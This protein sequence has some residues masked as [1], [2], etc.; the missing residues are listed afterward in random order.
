MKVIKF[1]YIFNLAAA[2]LL[3]QAAFAQT[4]IS[5]TVKDAGGEPVIGAVVMLQ[6]NTSVGTA[7][8]VDGKYSLLL[9]A[10]TKDPKLNL[11]CL[12]YAEQTVDVNGRATID[13]T[14]QNDD[15]MI[16]ETV[17]VGYGSVRKSDI[18]GSISTVKID[19]NEASKA[20]SIAA[21]LQGHAPGVQVTNNGGSPDGGVSI[22]VRGNSS[23]NCS[24]EPLYVVDGIILNTSSVTEKAMFTSSQAGLANYGGNDETNGL[25]GI[26]PQDIESM[27]VLK[28]ASATAIYGAQ[29]ENGVVLITT[30]KAK[31][32]RPSIRFNAGVDVTT[33]YE[34]R[35]ILSS[36]EWLSLY[37]TYNPGA[38]SYIY[39]DPLS[40]SGKFSD[41]IDWQDYMMHPA[42]SQR[43]YFNV[44]GKPSE[45]RYNFSFGYNNTNGIINN[46]GT[47]QYT[48]RLN[49]DKTVRKKLTFGTNVN[50]AYIDSDLAAHS[51]RLSER[52]SNIRSMVLSIPFE[53]DY[54]LYDHSDLE[55][56]NAA[57]LVDK[58]ND[59]NHYLN[60]RK[61][62]RVIPNLYAEYKIFPFLNFRSSVG[63]DVRVS[64]RKNFISNIINTTP[65]GNVAARLNSYYFNWNWDNTLNFNQQF[66]DHYIN[67]MLGTSTFSGFSS[68]Q[69]ITGW[70]IPTYELGMEGINSALY[71]FTSYSESLSRTFSYFARAVYSF[72]DR[73][74]LTATFRADGS[75]KFQDDNK[76]GYFPSGAFAWRLNQ[77]PWFKVDA[78]S[79][80]KIRVGW[81]R[82]GNQGLS[83][84]KTSTTYSSVELPIHYAS[85]EGVKTSS[86]IKGLKPDN[87]ANAG[88]K[89]ETTEST[90]IG[91]DLGLW[92][93]RFTFTAD[94]YNKETYGLLQVRDIPVSSGY[95]SIWINQ[96]DIRNRGLELSFEAVPIAAKDFEWS[97]HGNISFNR[98][99]L[100]SI[101]EDAA[102]DEIWVTTDRKE[103][104]VYYYGDDLE[105]SSYAKAALN[106]FMEGYPMGLF[107]GYKVKGIIQQGQVGTPLGEGN[108]PRGE[109]YLDY[110]D[111]NGNGYIDPEDRTIIGDPNPDFTYGF[112]TS[113]TW[114]GF[115]LNVMFNGV[116]GN[117]IYNAELCMDAQAGMT[118]LNT[119]RFV[120]DDAWSPSNPNAKW[121]AL[122]HWTTSMDN[123]KITSQYV[124]DG[125]YL[126]L[127]NVALSYDIKIKDKKS[128]VKGIGLTAS[129][130]NL[131]IWTNYHGWD[132]DVS[133]FGGDTTKMGVDMGSYPHARTFSFDVN[134]R[135]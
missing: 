41:G 119:R 47:K 82:V 81:G 43:Y 83:P 108:A 58:Y 10:G 19:E 33:C 112:G 90:N 8:D 14:M 126:R 15:M 75:S 121:P 50:L 70:N 20:T 100:V 42:L 53:V 132:P 62:F 91:L 48:M 63:A 133:S 55:E 28:D 130:S 127:S 56:D 95:S 74:I 107:Y 38:L 86:V 88:L 124:E 13:F 64:E 59:P 3:S 110:Y 114:K 104:V 97:L 93:G 105:N 118:G 79:N 65:S 129:A 76:W 17:V 116:Y 51:G 72:K 27:E 5:G 128:L 40:L 84:Y 6:G 61:E 80:A 2:L 30:K 26:N 125:S 101:N 31:T 37:S 78:V 54:E 52:S 21:L 92:D 120:I 39:Y 87:L 68:D 32:D 134:F 1:I 96:G 16:E 103:N 36:D 106:I 25:M 11:S 71:N 99:T 49:V 57:N 109:G 67:A 117:D 12:G 24:N 29:G 60:T 113:L 73:Y 18:T 4:M 123:Q 69:Q 35:D 122:M 45:T 9:P 44:S 7:T 94:V 23:L 131:K 89:W 85:D 22:R 66:G 34:K 98:N 115:S 77:E 135:F 102:T 111:L 46:T